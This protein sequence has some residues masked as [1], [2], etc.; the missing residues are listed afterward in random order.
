MEE[1][2]LKQVQKKMSLMLRQMHIYATTLLNGFDDPLLLGYFK[3][4]GNF[5]ALN[6]CRKLQ[7]VFYQL[8]RHTK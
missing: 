7:Q 6:I 3:L 4:A 1:G 8:A 5:K 2:N